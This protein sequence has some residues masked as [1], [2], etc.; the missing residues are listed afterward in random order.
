MA[1]ATAAGASDMVTERAEA[2][3]ALGPDATPAQIDEQL[4]QQIDDRGGVPERADRTLAD[5]RLGDEPARDAQAAAEDAERARVEELHRRAELRH[6]ADGNVVGS[7]HPA[8]RV[9][10]QD[11]AEQ[12][13]ARGESDD[14]VL[15]ENGHEVPTPANGVDPATLYNPDDH[16]VDEVNEYLRNLGENDE[17]DGD[18][19]DAERERV[20][21]A[22]RAGK[23]R[24]GITGGTA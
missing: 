13:L 24:V 20:L 5:G 14:D 11:D 21:A 6:D 1:K 10:G 7:S 18:A 4:Q 8:D 19:V 2:Q 17:F 22:E 9:D 15:R 3:Q 23:G 16:T 12:R